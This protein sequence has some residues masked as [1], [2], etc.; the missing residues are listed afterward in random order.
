[1]SKKSIFTLKNPPI[2]EVVYGVYFDKLV[3]FSSIHSGLIYEK[4]ST[5]YPKIEDKPPLIVRTSSSEIIL[6]LLPPL[7]RTWM[8]N[9]DE[10]SLIQVQDNMFFCNWRRNEKNQEYSRYN[11]LKKT[12]KDNLKKFVSYINKSKIGDISLSGTELTYINHLIKGRDWDTAQ[13]LKESLPIFSS[14]IG[15]KIPN[16]L[17]DTLQASINYKIP[18]NNSILGVKIGQSSKHNN[19]ITYMLEISAKYIGKEIDLSNIDLWFD[20][21]HDKILE[22]FKVVTSEGIRN[23]KWK[24]EN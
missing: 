21:M 2:E 7:R 16:T 22:L 14:L 11:N 12:F 18:D 17:Q 23:E 15:E 19:E 3:K 8:I 5:S 10:S 24:Q 4:F 6:D 1:M 20:N 9:E 13:D